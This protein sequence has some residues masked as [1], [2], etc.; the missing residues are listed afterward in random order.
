MS[1]RVP[2][3]LERRNNAAAVKKAMLD[4][5]RAVTQ[6]PVLAEQ[7]RLKRIAINEARAAREAERD[8]ARKVREAE[9]AAQ[10]ARE[11]ELAA[12]AKREAEA[13]EALAKAE[14]AERALALAA[15]QKAVRDAR[16][17]A[18]KAAKKVRRRGY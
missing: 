9:L 3:V 12:Q 8:A 17:A 6:D 13:A 16:Y 14:E 18:R 4:K 10:A 15:E 11:A 5:F 1:F 2:D 7:Q